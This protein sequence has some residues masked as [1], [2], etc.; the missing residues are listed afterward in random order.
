MNNKFKKA[1][2]V[3]ASVAMV[4]STSSFLPYNSFNIVGE[5]TASANSTLQKKAN[6]DIV[7]L[8][9]GADF[10]YEINGT[11]YDCIVASSTQNEAVVI[12]K[13]V[14]NPDGDKFETKQSMISSCEEK[15]G[16]LI[17]FAEYQVLSEYGII[18]M[19]E[20]KFNSYGCKEY[21]VCYCTNGTWEWESNYKWNDWSYF[22]AFDLKRNPIKTVSDSLVKT[23]AD[24]TLSTAKGENFTW[25]GDCE[26]KLTYYDSDMVKLDDVP[27][28]VGNYYVKASV[29]LV[30]VTENGEEIRYEASESNYIT[31]KI[32]HNLTH[33]EVKEPTC[34]EYGNIA[35]WYC[36]ECKK[37]FSDEACTSETTLEKTVIEATGHNLQKT[38]E[39]KPTCTENGNIAYWK[40]DDC[41]TC[42][43]DENGSTEINQSE[44]VTSATGHKYSD[45]KCT[46]CGTFEDGIGARLAGHSI[47]LDGNIGVNFYMELD[48]SV[49]KDENAYMQFTLPNG[50]IQAVNV[51]QAKKSEVNGK[52]YYVFPCKVA[53]KEM[54]DKITAQMITSDGE[55]TVYEYSVK[56]YADYITS[57]SNDYYDDTINLVESMMNYGN[58]A[59]AYFRKEDTT[60]IS[61]VTANNLVAFVKKLGEELP[62]G[63]TYY[64]SSLLLESNTT[65]RHYFKVKEDMKDEHTFTG[66]KN[67]YCYTDITG[68]SA[69]NL[70]TP[71][72]TT[73]GEWSISYSPMSY[74]Y[75]VL[76]SD[77]ASDNLKNLVKALYLYNQA[78]EAY[79]N[80]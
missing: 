48:E 42:F 43:S 23:H 65:V 53:T 79:Q 25:Q 31:F 29:P 3:F 7:W 1:I 77:T 45:G 16:R 21:D 34:T 12:W 57:H 49:V 56:E 37:Y 72:T 11:T 75:D 33:T 46:V 73:I 10:T 38:E 68:I 28:G 4:L 44:T 51:S 62:D 8:E 9:V 18:D 71:Q 2:V 61:D 5:I 30:V 63:I 69:A 35:Y 26:I 80:K 15:G 36:S 55:G 14:Q 54:Q 50:N 70:G 22:I 17:K 40:C 19:T 27:T 78:A 13:N 67:G 64:G 66:Q 41:G 24:P 20:N 39:V 58:S 59:K 6:A 47:S 74:A 52:Q 76:N 60:D 32:N